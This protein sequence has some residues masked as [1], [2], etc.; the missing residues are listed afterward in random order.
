MWL[1]VGLTRQVLTSQ[2]ALIGPLAGS[3]G[4]TEGLDT[5]GRA[6]ILGL[7]KTLLRLTQRPS[8]LVRNG[9]VLGTRSELVTLAFLLQRVSILLDPRYFYCG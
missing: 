5:E 3:L 1:D 9:I 2:L 4:T 6:G 8:L 7:L